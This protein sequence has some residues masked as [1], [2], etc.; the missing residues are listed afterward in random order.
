MRV[1]IPSGARE[2]RE[3]LAEAEW[4]HLA[5]ATPSGPH[6]TPLVFAVDGGR[7]WVTTSRSSVKAR[8]W[9]AD[10]RTAGMVRAG[11]RALLFRGR[12]RT[13]DALDPFTWPAAAIASP[14]LGKAATKFTLKNA[15]FFFGYAV[16]AYRVP[17]A[18]APT[19]RVFVSVEMAA[20]RVVDV[21]DGSVIDGW[22]SWARG[23]EPAL[24]YRDPSADDAA[25]RTARTVRSRL[26][27]IPQEILDAI[28]DQGDG[29]LSTQ[30]EGPDGPILTVLPTRWSA[31]GPGVYDAVV[32]IRT[33][34]LTG[35]GNEVRAGLTMDRASM[36]RASEMRGLLIR[37]SARVF[38]PAITRRGAAALAH[39]VAPQEALL[40]LSGERITWWEGW[41]SGTVVPLHAA[42]RSGARRRGGPR[43][44]V[45]ASPSREGRD[46]S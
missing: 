26:R 6:V 37:G 32:P 24:I 23:L 11:D 25:A 15:R 22:G 36:W 17:L 30:I 33:A 31:A 4:C 46:A 8:A 41:A 16:D 21:D 13:Y 28:G 2:A 20:A 9:R 45:R 40:R 19:G 29:V 14:R 34:E 3:L 12:V 10:P 38:A 27:A 44:P 39:R 5:A 43:S 42:G 35:A 18:W 1:R 7:I